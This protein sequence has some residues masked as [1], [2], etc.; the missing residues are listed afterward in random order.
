MDTEYEIEEFDQPTDNLIM[1]MMKSQP[2]RYRYKP[3]QE[4]DQEAELNQLISA[5][6]LVQFEDDE[7]EE[8][9]ELQELVN[10]DFPP[11]RDVT[12]EI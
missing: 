1:N 9:S 6:Q 5:P 11:E 7:E 8:I 4:A 12:H 3:T 10:V 2:S